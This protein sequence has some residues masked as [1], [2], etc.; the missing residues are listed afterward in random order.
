MK[1]NLQKDMFDRKLRYKMYKDG[2]KWVFASMATLSLIGA[3]LGGGS[4]H[5]DDKDVDQSQTTDSAEQANAPN[6]D[7]T[8]VLSTATEVSTVSAQLSNSAQVDASDVAATVLSASVSA[9]A[10]SASSASSVSTSLQSSA[11]VK[12]TFASISSSASSVTTSAS[13]MVSSNASSSASTSV[14]KSVASSSAK[15]SA[16]V[17]TS[18]VSAT[19]KKST[20]A[21]VSSS[22]SHTTSGVSYSVDSAKSAATAVTSIVAAMH[23]VAAA[24]SA[25][26][27]ASKTDKVVRNTAMEALVDHIV[28]EANGVAQSLTSAQ[29]QA[30][31]MQVKNADVL[32]MTVYNVV[33][34]MTFEL[35]QAIQMAAADKRGVQDDVLARA[36]SAYVNLDVSRFNATAKLSAYGDLIVSA[37]TNQFA[38]VVAALHQTGLYDDFR[39]VVDPIMTSAV[40]DVT[41]AEV[42][43]GKVRD[44]LILAHN[45]DQIYNAFV[46]GGTVSKTTTSTIKEGTGLTSWTASA[47]SDPTTAP[48]N[49]DAVPSGD[50]SSLTSTTTV[51]GDT[52]Y[53][54]LTGVT[55]ADGTKQAAVKP[56]AGN[57]TYKY[58]LDL[59]GNF[60]I[61]GKFFMSNHSDS[62]VPT[63]NGMQN[64]FQGGATYPSGDFLGLFL[65]PTDPGTIGGTN[66]DLGIGGLPDAIAFG[67]D[68]FYNS[69]KGD[70]TFGSNT[71]ETYQK[72]GYPVAGFRTTDANGN[73]TNG[74][75]GVQYTQNTSVGTKYS[76]TTQN[77]IP[78][79]ILTTGMPYFLSYDA[80][81][82][83][84]TA[85]MPKP[86]STNPNDKSQYLTWTYTLPQ[87]LLKKGVLSLGLL[88]VTG[89]NGAV[90]EASI[91]VTQRNPLTGKDMHFSGTLVP[92]SVTVKYQDA[93]GKTLLPDTSMKANVGDKIGIAYV[94]PN[95]QIDDYAYQAPSSSAIDSTKYK[96]ISAN[97]VTVSGSKANV[98]TLVYATRQTATVHYMVNGVA[99]ALPTQKLSGWA[100]E[101]YSTADGYS[102]LIWAKAGYSI[103]AGYLNGA[104]DSDDTTDQP[105]WIYI[106][107]NAQTVKT[108]VTGLP[109]TYA[110]QIASETQTIATATD[111][112][113]DLPAAIEVPGYKLVV[114]DAAGN[115][116]K[117]YTAIKTPAGNAGD[118]INY[119]YAYTALPDSIKVYYTYTDPNTGLVKPVDT[120]LIGLLNINGH[121]IKYDAKGAPYI[122]LTGVTDDKVDLTKLEN[123]TGGYSWDGK[124][125]IVNGKAATSTITVMNADVDDVVTI[126]FTQQPVIATIYYFALRDGKYTQFAPLGSGTANTFIYKGYANT[127]MPTDPATSAQLYPEVSG[128]EFVRVETGNVTSNSP[129][130]V[131]TDTPLDDAKTD[132][133]LEENTAS[134]KILSADSRQNNVF[135][136][137]AA[138]TQ[139]AVIKYVDQT[140]APVAVPAGTPTSLTGVTGEAYDTTKLTPDVP[141]YSNPVITDTAQVAGKVDSGKTD[142]AGQT[143]WTPQAVTVANSGVFGSNNSTVITVTYQAAPQV[144]NVRYVDQ[145]GNPV[146][147]MSAD[148]PTTLTGT[149]NSPLANLVTAAMKTAP[150]GYTYDSTDAATTFDA[151]TT[152]DQTVTV[153]FIAA[154]QSATVRY[155]LATVDADGKV[156]YTKTA[157][158]G[159]TPVSL[160]GTTGADY[161]SNGLY[162]SAVTNKAIPGYTRLGIDL[163]TGKFVDGTN[164]IT[165]G[166]VADEA[167]LQV[168]YYLLDTDNKDNSYQMSTRNGALMTPDVPALAADQLANLHT[169]D[170]ITL[171][172]PMFKGYV[173]QKADTDLSGLAG[174]ANGQYTVK[175]GTNSI[176][177]YF[178][179][180]TQKATVNFV[181]EAGKQ[182]PG[183]ASRQVTGP[184]NSPIQVENEIPGWTK[185]DTDANY[186]DDDDTVDQVINIRYAQD[187][188]EQ[189]ILVTYPKAVGKSDITKPVVT[190]TG[191][192]GETFP[193]FKLTGYEIPGY[194]MLVDGKAATEIAAE[195]A[196]ATNN[197]VGGSSIAPL[198]SPDG[199]TYAS[200]V[201]GDQQVHIITY[202]ANP[203]TLTTHYYLEGAKGEKTGTAAVP[204]LKTV[205]NT[206]LTTDAAVT[207]TDPTAPAGYTLV[208]ADSDLAGVNKLADGSY[209]ALMGDNTITYWFTADAQAAKVTYKT[210][211]GTTVKAAS[212][213]DGTA[214]TEVDGVTDE[215]YKTIDDYKTVVSYVPKGYTLQSVVVNGQTYTSSAAALAAL[216]KLSAVS[217]DNAIVMNY[218]ADLQK[219]VI[220]FRVNQYAI[221]DPS[222]L[223][224]QYDMPETDQMSFTLTGTTGQ[225]IDYTKISQYLS[226]A[227]LPTKMSAYQYDGQ[228]N[229]APDKQYSV[230]DDDTAT[231]QTVVL[232]YTGKSINYSFVVLS[233]DDTDAFDANGN[234]VG[235]KNGV[236]VYGK[237]EKFSVGMGYGPS[238]V[239]N[240]SDFTQSNL[241]LVFVQT[242]AGG[243]N[244]WNTKMMVN[245]NVTNIYDATTA[246]GRKIKIASVSNATVTIPLGDG[247]NYV[248]KFGTGVIKN[249]DGTTT[250]ATSSQ[251]YFYITLNADGTDPNTGKLVT[252]GAWSLNKPM[253]GWELYAAGY[254]NN[255]KN[256]TD[257]GYPIAK[258]SYVQNG[259]TYTIQTS[260]ESPWVYAYSTMPTM[261]AAV[262]NNSTSKTTATA[263]NAQ[264]PV[265][266]IYYYLKDGIQ[267]VNVNFLNQS[268]EK[269]GAGTSTV[270]GYANTTIDYSPIDS[271]AHIKGY[272]L[273]SDGRETVTTY[274]TVGVTPQIEKYN[275]VKID[276]TT[277]KAMVN[278]DTKPQMVN[279]IYKA[280]VQSASVAFVGPDGKALKNNVN[281]PDGVTAGTVDFSAITAALKAIPGY[282]IVTDLPATATFD[283]SDNVNG[284]DAEP[285]VF[286]IVYAKDAQ[287]VHVNYMV[288]NTDGALTKMPGKDVIA[289]NG[290]TGD[291]VDYKSVDKVVKGYTLVTDETT[292]TT[293][294]DK[295][296]NGTATADGTPQ[297]VNLVYTANATKVTV[298]YRVQQMT[299]DGAGNAIPLLDAAG[300]PVYKIVTPTVGAGMVSTSATGVYGDKYTV[301][302]ANEGMLKQGYTFQSVSFSDGTPDEAIEN[303]GMVTTYP[304]G[305]GPNGETAEGTTSMTYTFSDADDPAAGRTVYVTYKPEQYTFDIVY[306]VLDPG[307]DNPHGV[308]VRETGFAGGFYSYDSPTLPLPAYITAGADQGNLNGPYGPQVNGFGLKANYENNTWEALDNLDTFKDPV[309]GKLIPKPH[310]R[311]TYTPKTMT[312]T[313][314][315]VLVNSKGERVT[316]ASGN[317]VFVSGN[318]VTTGAMGNAVTDKGWYGITTA[319]NVDKTAPVT[320]LDKQIKGYVL[321]NA[322]GTWTSSALT[323]DFDAGTILVD[324]DGNPILDKDKSVQYVSGTP[325]GKLDA[326]PATWQAYVDYANNVYDAYRTA[327]N[328]KNQAY[329]KEHAA[330]I[331]AGTLTSK[332]DLEA[333]NL[334]NIQQTWVNLGWTASNEYDAAQYNKDA[335][336]YNTG[337]NKAQIDAGTLVARNLVDAEATPIIHKF[338]PA[339]NYVTYQYKVDPTITYTYKDSAG[340]VINKGE[341]VVDADG[342]SYYSDRTPAVIHVT[343]DMPA[344]GGGAYTVT[345]T[346]ADIAGFSRSDAGALT[347]NGNAYVASGV[348]PSTNYDVVFTAVPQKI[349][350]SYVSDTKNAA[351]ATDKMP[352]TTTT[353]RD[354]N[355]MYTVDAT[356]GAT[357][358]AGY[359]V[360]QITYN[361]TVVAT[362]DSATSGLHQ[363]DAAFTSVDEVVKAVSELG[364]TAN[365]IEY[366]LTAAPEPLQVTY[367][368]TT[369]KVANWTAPKTTIAANVN[370]TVAT[371]DAYNVVVPTVAGYTAQIVA[372]AADGTVLNT[373]T[374]TQFKAI[375][376]AGL[377]MT[378]DG[379]YYDVIYTPAVQNIKTSYTLPKNAK[380]QMTQMTADTVQAATDSTYDVTADG[381]LKALIPR[382]YQVATITINGQELSVDDADAQNLQ[383]I[384]GDNTVV[385]NLKASIQP[386]TVNYGFANKTPNAAAVALLPGKSTGTN[387][388][389][390]ID[391]VSYATGDNYT[392]VVPKIA[393]YVATVTTGDKDNQ[394]TID[395]TAP[396]Q[397]VAGGAT[398]N[399]VY[400]PE[401]Q[402][403]T[404][405]YQGPEV[406]LDRMSKTTFVNQTA[407]DASFTVSANGPA[408]DVPAGYKVEKVT[409]N[410]KDVQAGDFVTSVGGDTI[411]YTLVATDNPLN[412]N[413][414][415]DTIKG[416]TAPTT[417]L[418][419]NIAD[420][421]VLTDVKYAVAVPD[422][423]GYTAS[424]VDANGNTYTLAQLANLPGMPAGGA[425]YTVTYTPN[426]QRV[427]VVFKLNTTDGV[428]MNGRVA[429]RIDGI[430]NGTVSYDKITDLD[431]PGYAYQWQNTVATFDSDDNQDQTVYIIYT[432]KSDQKAKLV[433]VNDPKQQ[434]DIDTTNGTTNTQITFVN[435]T[436]KQTLTDQDLVR[437]GYTYVLAGTSN[438]YASLV[439]L[440]KYTDADDDTQTYDVTYTAKKQ[441][442]GIVQSGLPTSLMT[443][444]NLAKIAGYTNGHYGQELDGTSNNTLPTATQLHVP[445]YAFQAYLVHADGTK[446]AV[447]LTA[448][449][450]QVFNLLPGTIDDNGLAVTQVEVDYTPTLQQAIVQDATHN[451][452]TATGQTGAKIVLQTTDAALAKAGYTYTVNGFSSL[453]DAVA[454]MATYDNTDNAADATV[455][456]TP[457]LFNVVYTAN[458]QSIPVKVVGLPAAKVPN[459]ANL[460]GV[461]DST[462]N[463]VPTDDQLKVP[464]YA[465]VITDS[466]NKAVTL[467]QLKTATFQ[468]NGEQLAVT[469]Y[470][471]TYTAEPTSA[472]VIYRYDSSATLENAPKL[473]ETTV[474]SGVTDGAYPATAIQT[475]PGYTTVV[476]AQSAQVTGQYD[477]ATNQINGTFTADDMSGDN[478]VYVVTYVPTDHD[479]KVH[480]AVVDEPSDATEPSGTFTLPADTK[481]S[482]KTDK[483]YQI[484]SVA[485]PGYEIEKIDDKVIDWDKLAKV[486]ETAEDGTIIT[487]YKLDDHTLISSDKLNVTFTNTAAV[488]ATGEL[489]TSHYDITLLPTK[490]DFDVTYEWADAATQDAAN[491]TAKTKIDAQV[492]SPVAKTGI[493]TDHKYGFSYV[494]VP[495]YTATVSGVAHV[496]DKTDS[497]LAGAFED[498]GKGNVTANMHAVNTSYKVVYSANKQHIDV[499][500]HVADTGMTD[501]LAVTGLPTDDSGI[502]TGS[503]EGQTDMAYTDETSGD[504]N[505]KLVKAVPGYTYTIT[506]AAGHVVKDATGKLLFMC[507]A[508]FD[509]STLPGTFA[510]DATTGALIQ[511]QY[512]IT[513]QA[514]KQQ[515]QITFENPTDP[516]T[517][518]APVTDPITQT[519]DSNQTFAEVDL[520]KDY[521]IPGYTMHIDGEAG[522]VLASQKADNTDVAYTFDNDATDEAL[523]QSVAATDGTVQKHVVT[524]VAN[525]DQKAS[526]TIVN[527]P[528]SAGDLPIVAPITDGTTDAKVD[529]GITQSQLYVPGYTFVVTLVGDATKTPVNIDDLRFTR[530]ETDD[531]AYEVTYTPISQTVNVN[532]KTDGLTT[533]QQANVP[534]SAA[535]FTL[536]GNTD[537]NYAAATVSGASNAVISG[538]PGYTFTVSEVHG[539]GSDATSSAISAAT[540]LG[541]QATFDLADAA[542]GY[543]FAVSGTGNESGLAVAGSEQLKTPEIDVAYTALPQHMQVTYAVAGTPT[544]A[545]QAR[546]DAGA[547]DNP[548]TVTATTDALLSVATAATTMIIHSVDG[549]TF[550]IYK[551][552]ADG[553][554]GD[555]V[556]TDPQTTD[557][558]LTKN[559]LTKDQL[560]AVD[561]D[562]NLV[563][564]GY[565]VV[566]TADKQTV[567]VN[568][569]DATT[570]M[571]VADQDTVTISGLSDGTIDFTAAQ[572]VVDALI[573]KGYQVV[574]G[575]PTDA[576]LYDNDDANDQTFTVTVRHGVSDEHETLA[577]TS[578]VAYEGANPA[579]EANVV[580]VTVTHTYQTDDVTGNR[581]Q[582]GDKANYGTYYKADTYVIAEADASKATVDGTTGDITFAT[583]DTPAVA[584]YTPDA[585][586]K[587]N[588]SAVI[589]DAET[590]A[591]SYAPVASTVTYTADV[592]KVVVTFKDLTTGKA[593]SGQEP[594]MITGVT[595]GTIDFTT[596]QDVVKALEEAGYYVVAGL[597]KTDVPYDNDD[598]KNQAY[599]VTLRHSVT[600]QSEDLTAT[601][602]VTYEG[603]NPE[604]KSNKATVTITHTYQTDN[605]TKQRIQAIAKDAYGADYVADTYTVADVDKAT[606][607][608]DK[609]TGALTYTA[610]ETPAVAG[611][612]PDKTSVSNTAEAVLNAETG[613]Y[614]YGPAESTVTYTADAQKVV[615]KFND[616]TTGQPVVKQTDVTIEGVTDGKVDFTTA[617]AA[618][619]AL[620]K[621]GYYVVA[622]LP[623]D[624]V[625]FDNKDKEDQSFTVTL[626]HQVAN[627]T[628]P[629]T[630]TSTV[631]YEGANPAPATNVVTVTVNHTYQMDKV[632]NTRIQATAKD[633]YVTDYQPDTYTVAVADAAKVT[634]NETTGALTYT[635][636]ETPAV[637][638]YTPDKMTVSNTATAV[639]NTETGEYSYGPA[640]STVTYT[641]D[642]QKVVVKFNDLTTGQPVAKQTD[643]TIDGVTDGTVD[644]KTAQDVVDKLV[645]AGYYVV[646]GL[647]TDPVLFDNKDKEDQS[648][649]VTLRHQVTNE[650]EPLTATSTVT[651]E[652]ANPAPATNVVTV[653]VNHTYQTDKVTGARI[654]A[655]AKDAYV[656]DYQPDTYTVAA[657]DAA[658]VT[659]DE[660]TGALTYTT[661]KTPAVAGY[662]PDKTSVSNTAEAVLNTETGE[663][664][665]APAKSTVT[666]TA[667]AQRVVVKFNDLTTGQPVAKQTDVTIEGV[668][669][670]TVD[671]KT[672]QDVVDKLVKA[673]YYVVAGLPTDPVLFD[674]KDKEDQ[675]F[676]VTL[677]H[678]VTNETEPLTA[679]STVTYE[680]ANPVPATNEVT[681]TVNHT[682]QTDKVTNTR[683]QATAKDAYVTD[684][685][686]DTYTVA[687]ADVA[688]VTVNETTGALTYTTVKTPTVAG[689]TPD[690]TSVS[691]EAEA[692]LHTETGEYS[693]GPVSTKVVYTID[694]VQKA[695]LHFVN[696]PSNRADKVIS[697]G[698]AYETIDFGTTTADL[699]VPGYSYVITDAD[700]KTY[701]SIDDFVYTAKEADSQ[702]YTVTYTAKPVE[703]AVHYDTE[704]LTAGQKTTINATDGVITGKTDAG[705]AT[706]D[707]ATTVK[708]VPG[709]T[710]TVTDAAKNTIVANR[711]SDYDLKEA[712]GTF[713]VNAAG[714]PING[715]FTVV[716]TPVA[717]SVAVD[718]DTA[719]L[720]PEQQ[721]TVAATD[722]KL[723]G[724]TDATYDTATGDK[725]VKAVPGYTFTITDASDKPVV[726]DATKPFDLTTVAGAFALNTDGK[727][728]ND[729]FKVVYT[730]VGQTVAVNYNTTELNDTQKSQ[731][732]APTTAAITGKTD[733]LNGTA[734]G[735]TTVKSVPGYTFTVTNNAGDVV[736][737]SEKDFDLK[738]VP[739]QFAVNSDG[740]LKNPSYTVVYTPELQQQTV[741]VTFPA[742]AG[743]PNV[744]GEV[745]NKSVTGDNFTVTDLSSYNVDGYTMLVD[746]KPATSIAA[747]AT[748]T[749]ANGLNKT[750]SKPQLHTVTFVA[751]TDQKA[752]L[753]FVNDPKQRDQITKN[754]GESDTTINFG[755]TTADLAVPGYS[756]VIT[757]AAGNTYKSIDGFVY[758]AKEADLQDYTVTYTAEPVTVAVHFDTT[759]L[760]KEQQATVNATDGEISGKTDADYTTAQGQTTVPAVPGYTF[761]VTNAAGK[762]V[763]QDATSDFDLTTVSGAFTVNPDGTPK[764]D[765]FT[766]V[767]TP[768]EQVVTVN[769][770]TTG[771]NATQKTQVNAPAT[772]TITGKTDA[773]NTTATGATTVKVVAGYTFTVTDATG[774]KI[775]EH[776]EANFDL[777]TVPGQFAVNPDGTLQN[778]SYTVVYTPEVQQQ[779]V[780]VTFPTSANRANETGTVVNT[781]V[782][783]QDFT[784]T[785]LSNYNVDGYTMLVDGVKTTMINP[786]ATDTTANGTSTTDSA[787]QVHNVTFVANTDQKATLTFVNDPKHRQPVVETTGTS[788]TTI[789]FGMKTADLAVPGYS[790]VITDA[791]GKTYT[792]IDEFVYTAK[793]ADSQDYTVTY[794]PA[795]QQQTVTVTFSKAAGR[796]NIVG[797]VTQ[798]STTGVD[799]ATV[800]LT[801]YAVPGYTM[802]VDGR[803][804]TSIAPEATDT[805]PNGLATVDNAP[806]G[807]QVT[808]VANA[809][810]AQIVVIDDTTGA[811]LRVDDVQGVTDG[812]VVYN[813]PATIKRYEAMG[814]V[815]VSD[816][817]IAGTHYDAIADA[818]RDSQIF[819]IHLQHDTVDGTGK[820]Q[821]IVRHTTIKTPDGK[822]VTV[823]QVVTVTPHF[824]VD[825]VTG[826]RVP[827]AAVTDKTKYAHAEMPWLETH[828]RTARTVVSEIKINGQT[829]ETDFG[830]VQVANMPGYKL[831]R[832][833]EPNG[834]QVV[835]FVATATAPV[836]P[837][838][839]VKAPMTT[840]QT[841]TVVTV[842]QP[843]PSVPVVTSA[844]PA[845]VSQAPVSQA[846]ITS[847]SAVNV[848][849]TTSAAPLE[850][851]TEPDVAVI[852]DTVVDGDEGLWIHE[853][854][855]D[856]DGD[857]SDLQNLHDTNVMTN[858]P[859]FVALLFATLVAA[860][861]FG[862]L[863]AFYRRR[864]A[865]ERKLAARRDD[866]D[867]N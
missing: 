594:V 193:A 639:L 630:A 831:V 808:F 168:I 88:G 719:N 620:V 740:T 661:I 427:N 74:T 754:D 500:Y 739:G 760:T 117:N 788:D 601:S 783:G 23:S 411:V 384:A 499:V 254:I 187:A 512:T 453:T 658:K 272:Q 537:T 298:V 397:M 120:K 863:M 494:V 315:Y 349:T 19:S 53:Y 839:S 28:E 307:A 116:V 728:V 201:D 289:I 184:S 452:E 458:N 238:P 469:D 234:F 85:S 277:G 293:T 664:S 526:L 580:S 123:L 443:A 492:A 532:Y 374:A 744:T 330:E 801:K 242:L 570:K 38:K 47:D 161:A 743:K 44:A 124:A 221:T 66:G 545:Q 93:S 167:T 15:Q 275:Q 324:A 431:V 845:L 101:A 799:F 149:S 157:V 634:V 462:Y 70:Q 63:V 296:N 713:A 585:E 577:A 51:D 33:N 10:S 514:D 490:Q 126:N 464:G 685:Q 554:R 693:Y 224:S 471:V 246:D 602:T 115:E 376:A 282:H 771:L 840:E 177:Y 14:K 433:F 435:P 666:Y 827:D 604:P 456:G 422:V 592:Q 565:D 153:H 506:D 607:T 684:Y 291:T 169:D 521:N 334:Q 731:V 742:S 832:T 486:T 753:T 265:Y 632:T 380:V 181:D 97:D 259:T 715:E 807:H 76:S 855:D 498:D 11:V 110:T 367:S 680:G 372:K 480:Y 548:T 738:K 695:S 428:D 270:K 810:K 790:Y 65:S 219:V 326:V 478:S 352:A 826:E 750:D 130:D 103:N 864:E 460:T 539:Q 276:P 757:D 247:T 843:T 463:N 156:T 455:D 613:E 288:Q 118:V 809:A 518:K 423:A 154:N 34:N 649:T 660:T 4:A 859:Y 746:G 534:G 523:A 312:V 365:Q 794:T 446:T 820:T 712:T 737:D 343:A 36:Q 180:T 681:V 133:T 729:H 782:T 370:D 546:V 626:R 228:N 261:V 726:S 102:D 122:E 257:V 86:G 262:D 665:Y 27:A 544:T 475:L 400:T 171:T 811:T 146:V 46:T 489:Q 830:D 780:N 269:I 353:V 438:A 35:Q 386:L 292:N 844:A 520:G 549:Y 141:G 373:Y 417:G 442:I 230:F 67:I 21:A 749:T 730:P 318:A 310:L 561:A 484:T 240:V 264:Q 208:T 759:M 702:D 709:Y 416:W 747:E 362:A 678:Q 449:G 556:T 814:Y 816:G 337:E 287:T 236:D 768:V 322:N 550:M 159:T 466:N 530:D 763:A 767:Y 90:M 18:S 144:A 608:V 388:T 409:L 75:G 303:R 137:Y 241:G 553:S 410:D 355:A 629:L 94:S 39:F 20:A 593:V 251:D 735:A 688:K 812:E 222:K 862:V 748:D 134:T 321:Q 62:R 806:Q 558:D 424:V 616:L 562:G 700:G 488:D 207:I 323:F 194:T 256:T 450:D 615:V 482:I 212:R 791:A 694:A 727:L 567:H 164:T 591:V 867:Q 8:V 835:T 430:S 459:L 555:L 686:P 405:L 851:I 833:N 83:V 280:N 255:A 825:R 285:Q 166:Y 566:Y 751:N 540:N 340:K 172:D 109:A 507:E 271:L 381:P 186:F 646:A 32:M 543:T 71:N 114:T 328:A 774:H 596:A 260:D 183:Q 78:A 233:T 734:D 568:F 461:T 100:T 139:K 302:T 434:A 188:Q 329:N 40:N 415:Y 633:A 860:G 98:M 375:A 515:Q 383:V 165:V 192:T 136:I 584:G 716:Y 325:D 508:D 294:F 42:D 468:M 31:H 834:D 451:F 858:D 361:K 445:G 821:T 414:Q 92:N 590:G 525:A 73:L 779:T 573:A 472:K 426:A 797:Q 351:A 606:V 218:K 618:V 641:A 677:R 623:T 505:Y 273:V 676:T 84:L 178:L 363:G 581:I 638:G 683:I 519:A 583:V 138:Q 412:V 3:F 96:L 420:E 213:T 711:T 687:T 82:H 338:Q 574:T 552:K 41:D 766:V 701:E 775:V 563:M 425:T 710:F 202:K 476:V 209:T 796:P 838:E 586:T 301:D 128:Y 30:T 239:H 359:Y 121:E 509:L 266:A 800:D 671:F 495:G 652:G 622:G 143:I 542:N 317:P 237:D 803:P 160:S 235:I 356:G 350:T 765:H 429:E 211:N 7:S 278:P 223:V 541:S 131:Q 6:S 503:L 204:G 651:Y 68:F 179:A 314:N 725:I 529:F 588:V 576:T 125:P 817:F 721:K 679:T 517:G 22:A 648:F 829:G 454:A 672:T 656:K 643:V 758:T 112:T 813:S 16:K 536:T 250:P 432:A 578:T 582:A 24:D 818:T 614:S 418:S 815:L 689:Y 485:T 524:Y 57:V 504:F 135:V 528:V 487:Y 587:Q 95:Y 45:D 387:A 216:D 155:V 392:V 723:D 777:T 29:Y 792:S 852:H 403:Q 396:I 9:V 17:T 345:D 217:A 258:Y 511:N 311:I 650:T 645:R 481:I 769:T 377:A 717:Q 398:Y 304:N 714:K 147:G 675:S 597:P 379:A 441:Q 551:K 364:T 662:T 560:F 705:Y 244:P 249:A 320:Q 107:S 493:Y 89:G 162:T 698:K 465:Y 798:T 174:G 48:K 644:F 857:V 762:V 232:S 473:P 861:M 718:Y 371:D 206:N 389:Q 772:A 866:G 407:T 610:V 770:D 699:H 697:D 268:G 667:D 722:G 477:A 653:T 253:T 647:P 631:T 274:D 152:L 190:Q 479:I 306:Y 670:G 395:P 394:S 297:E 402:T 347:F 483:G 621:A 703:V 200:D 342:N 793:E 502:L 624:P 366:T 516:A 636:I 690:K 823:E 69:N 854:P 654:Q 557:F 669:D 378:A 2:K 444:N 625:L 522:T 819:E 655:T 668:T 220:K 406:A 745:V 13:V 72:N 849:P 579:P 106:T 637:A 281:L 55:S 49:T 385:Y 440:P 865:T 575:L 382:G 243:I 842:L 535:D 659:V 248:Q 50:A 691:N 25:A 175:A 706:A 408:T 674:N 12:S 663:Y 510:V 205:V 327:Q 773:L 215:S 199:K 569:E 802:L 846:V 357:I 496:D 605:V 368:Y 778:P 805:T 332:S 173:L 708:A 358:P 628:E 225:K 252:K 393:G 214:I 195:T 404:T 191:K 79:G 127:K 189:A 158:P 203:A 752:R 344:D 527:K 824:S 642:A 785:D 828:D 132:Y 547:K 26:I 850:P 108:T 390:D 853:I 333:W 707:G 54:N 822:V 37:P 226:T 319:G 413:Y 369:A 1:M 841:P 197:P 847:A 284:A 787:P 198:S 682:Y 290:L 331:A 354:T 229:P 145:N 113:Y 104:F 657:A 77:S 335:E 52:Q 64:A 105:I 804:A 185:I 295:T 741:N 286:T 308:L 733:A 87:E 603:A 531:Q 491:A 111:S 673:G 91:D 501:V 761:T 348:L 720:T 81:S 391:K 279:L 786:E 848:T 419:T 856:K 617:Q 764:N 313:A 497:D 789:S 59:S 299:T 470:T 119:T 538:R 399:V 182:I 283:D 196:D 609:T 309:T 611:Y 640:E 572:T 589:V 627:E 60:T 600:P 336:A 170:V 595:D 43:A 704:N 776:S 533:A 437:T 513:Y 267:T 148:L 692:V 571:A 163:G 300:Q 436:T 732:K 61:T 784:A 176:S 346:A 457:Q 245:G 421:A 724:V 781:T 467:D 564:P 612:T 56:V 836:I 559:A 142:E 837:H 619:D 447:D 339:V 755:T 58:Q 736:K 305:A 474:I 150:A 151:D 80:T 360:S 635:T 231:D 341:P 99:N 795:V 140:G 210:D 316:D 439:N 5:A 448:L 599:E 263:V 756:Y 227:S 129:M 598:A 401:A 696:D